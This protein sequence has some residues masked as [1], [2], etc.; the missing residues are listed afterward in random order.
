MII[1]FGDLIRGVL[2]AFLILV[3][4]CIPGISVYLIFKYGYG[5]YLVISAL[6]VLA[7]K[8]GRDIKEM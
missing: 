3:G 7:Y 8:I 1:F 5:H 2:L 6:L 4:L